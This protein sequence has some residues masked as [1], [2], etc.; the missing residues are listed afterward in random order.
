MMQAGSIYLRTGYNE[1]KLVMIFFLLKY[2]ETLMDWK[3]CDFS[4]RT[5]Y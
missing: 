2:G 4:K 5:L 1:V 3:T